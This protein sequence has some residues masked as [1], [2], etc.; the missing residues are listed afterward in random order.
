M[1]YST[2]IKE[3][4]MNYDFN[5]IEASI[6]LTALIKYDAKISKD[7]IVISVE[8]AKI[9]RIIFIFIKKL[10]NIN[11]KIIVRMQKRFHVKQIYILEINDK[12]NDI[13]NYLNINK[14]SNIYDYLTSEEEKKAYLMGTFLACGS[15]SDPKN[16]GYHLEFFLPFKKD[17]L[18][19]KSLLKD[20]NVD[21]K[22]IK[23]NNK[24]MTYV[25]S[26][27]MIS[28]FLKLVNAISNLFYF[29]DI[30][31]YRDHKN[32]V[33]RLNNCELANQE[34]ITLNGMKQLKDIKYLEDNDLLDLLDEKV[35]IVVMYRKKYP[36]SSYSEL[37]E[38][39]SLETDYKITKSGINHNFIKVRNLIEHHQK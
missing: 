18:L 22:I 37:A 35:A 30:R 15:I 28:D 27:E 39:I 20:F 8:N 36:E 6:T 11:A 17:A 19:L 3:E 2:K 38:I 14:N 9:A 26:A 4:I 21:A 5:R 12:I 13:L 31:I 1:T 24:Y 29:E 10:F 23:R 34:K 16:S 33:N 32:M 7:K 25:K